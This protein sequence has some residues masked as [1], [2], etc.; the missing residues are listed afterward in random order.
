MR[1]ILISAGELTDSEA[2]HQAPNT[3]ELKFQVDGVG[4]D[5]VWCLVLPEPE[6]GAGSFELES[7]FDDSP[8]PIGYAN[9]TKTVLL[10]QRCK[11][12]AQ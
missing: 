7:S 12:R 3:R 8:A 1:R 9:R 5:D 11:S 10:E 4:S 6:V 2:P